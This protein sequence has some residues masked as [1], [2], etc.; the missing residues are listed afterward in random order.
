MAFTPP[1][2]IASASLSGSVTVTNF[3]ADQLV[4]FVQPVTVDASGFTVPVSVESLPLPDGAASQETLER[5]TD[6]LNDIALT[7]ILQREGEL[8]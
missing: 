6:S 4:H 7:A 5:A 1:S 2:S 8:E 3:P